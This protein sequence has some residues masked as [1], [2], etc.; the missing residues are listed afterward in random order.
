M[1]KRVIPTSDGRLIEVTEGVLRIPPPPDNS[2]HKPK[3]HRVN[4]KKLEFKLDGSRNVTSGKRD[5]ESW[6]AL[7]TTQNNSVSFDMKYKVIG[8][9]DGVRR[10]DA[11]RMWDEGI[12]QAAKD[13]ENIKKNFTFE[14]NSAEEALKGAL[15]VLRTP[16]SQAIKLQAARLLLDF[17]KI[18]P[19]SKSEVSVNKAEDWLK[20]LDDEP[21]SNS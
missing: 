18:K 17:T 15:E 12:K 3:R 14:D 9:V 4:P 11:L 2:K 16:G 8:M 5:H 1:T 10:E 13:M 20:S 7:R 19:V 6:K 21:E